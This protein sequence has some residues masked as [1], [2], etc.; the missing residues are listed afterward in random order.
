MSYQFQS[1]TSSWDEAGIPPE[2]QFA[3]ILLFNQISADTGE[4]S[5]EA[6]KQFIVGDEQH[7]ST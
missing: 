1:S 4:I 6:G 2:E 3:L 5:Q 7:T